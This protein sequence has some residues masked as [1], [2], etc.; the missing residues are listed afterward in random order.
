M[1][2]WEELLFLFLLAPGGCCV[3]SRLFLGFLAS[4]EGR[5]I[6]GFPQRHLRFL[7]F[8]AF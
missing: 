1:W 4:A 8:L 2:R 3:F 5:Q 7:M 6:L